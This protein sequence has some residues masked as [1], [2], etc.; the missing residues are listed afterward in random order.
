MALRGKKDK[1]K[2]ET[3]D[4]NKKRVYQITKKKKRRF[5]DEKRKAGIWM[6]GRGK[7]ILKGAVICRLFGV[8]WGGYFFL[9]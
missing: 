9:E 8:F 5:E 7:E 6:G 3:T 1:K 2:L 4:N